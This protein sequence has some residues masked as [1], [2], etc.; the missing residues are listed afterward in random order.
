MRN[1][2]QQIQAEYAKAAMVT[3]S[4]HIHTHTQ[5]QM[6][7]SK[8]SWMQYSQYGLFDAYHPAI[9]QGNGKCPVYR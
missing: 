8:N 4:A 7:S 3:Q 2:K 6:I 5:N 1:W 9:K